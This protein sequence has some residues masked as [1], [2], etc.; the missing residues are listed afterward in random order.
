[1]T[2]IFIDVGANLILRILVIYCFAVDT[3]SLCEI[4][5]AY[6]TLA[7]HSNPMHILSRIQQMLIRNSFSLSG[8]DSIGRL[9][10]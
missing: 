8:S 4:F 3:V 2:E 9:L 1:M 7:I 5:F 10:S 6:I